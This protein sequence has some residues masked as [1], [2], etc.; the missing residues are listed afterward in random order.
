MKSAIDIEKINK[1]A[2]KKEI[3]MLTIFGLGISEIN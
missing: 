2:I 3:N 1:A